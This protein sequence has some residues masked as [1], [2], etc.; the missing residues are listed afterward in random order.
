MGLPI[1]WEKLTNMAIW[2]AFMGMLTLAVGGTVFYWETGELS[3]S[4]YAH[5]EVSETALQDASKERGFILETL[6]ELKANQQKA[7]RRAMVIIGLGGQ[8]SFG[9]DSSYVRI[10]INSNA[11]VY[12]EEKLVKITNLAVEGTPSS[13]MAVDGTFTNSNSNLKVM[14]SRRAADDLEIEGRM[15][16]KLEPIIE[17]EQ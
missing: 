1:N 8:G 2:S 15:E 6:L 12:A 5:L 3:E 17:E 10:N 14:F 13:D 7:E 9:T 4:Y 16:V 11:S